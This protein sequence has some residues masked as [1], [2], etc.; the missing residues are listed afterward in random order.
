L[1]QTNTEAARWPSSTLRLPDESKYLLDRR[2][3]IRVA[4]LLGDIAIERSSPD[5]GHAGF[6]RIS[7]A[8]DKIVY[9]T[10]LETV[11]T[12]KTLLRIVGDHPIPAHIHDHPIASHIRP[13][14]V[15]RFPTLEFD[16]PEGCCIGSKLFFA[17]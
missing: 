16:T 5:A 3:P 12:P 7:Q 10:S 6:A 4:G 2:R 14:P 15:C 8:A 1:S 9:S 11:S 17:P 13:P